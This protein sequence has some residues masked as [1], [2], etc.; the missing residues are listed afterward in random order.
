LKIRKEKYKFKSLFSFFKGSL[1]RRRYV[2]KRKTKFLI[3]L[4]WN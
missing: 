1:S 3:T 4:I 2:I